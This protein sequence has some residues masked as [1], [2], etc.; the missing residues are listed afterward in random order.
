[1][2]CKGP[3]EVHFEWHPVAN[4][5]ENKL[6]EKYHHAIRSIAA[7]N[8]SGI[9]CSRLGKIL[10]TASIAIVQQVLARINFELISR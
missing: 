10:A 2:H 5:T 1:V 8:R 9:T 4:Q 3:V 6:A 7:S